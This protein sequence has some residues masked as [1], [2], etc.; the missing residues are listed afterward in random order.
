VKHRVQTA[1]TEHSNEGSIPSIEFLRST[2]G[3]R[4]QTHQN[5]FLVPRRMGLKHRTQSPRGEHAAHFEIYEW[6]N[7]SASGA[8][9]TVT[10]EAASPLQGIL[11]SIPENTSQECATEKDFKDLLTAFFFQDCAESLPCGS[12][13]LPVSWLFISSARL[14]VKVLGYDGVWVMPSRSTHNFGSLPF[15][16]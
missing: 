2:T 9:A 10:A 5:P 7:S 3:Y 15:R 13:F 1:K 16:P 12:I 8:Y 4:C 6:T 11:C 14:E